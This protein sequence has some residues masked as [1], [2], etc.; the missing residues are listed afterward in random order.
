[1]VNGFCKKKIKSRLTLGEKF[2]Q[3]RKRKKISLLQAEIGSKVRSKYLEAIELGKWDQLPQEVYVR[4]FVLSYA[5]FLEITE[6]QILPLYESESAILREKADG[7][8]ISYN[9]TIETNKKVLI[10]PRLLAFSALGVFVLGMVSYIV[11]QLSDFAGNPN[12]KITEP[13]NNAVY[14][15]DS[16]DMS[17]ITDDD[18]VVMINEEK[19]PVTSDGHFALNL[20]LHKGINVIKVKAV[21]K[22]QKE[23]SEVFTVEYKP[24]TAAI[25]NT[26]I[27]Q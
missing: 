9:Q 22:I 17:G 19:V 14:E 12:L 15:I 11:I 26:V 6:A 8:K 24:K 3:V 7:N 18:T 5:K 23:T 25:V 10:T 20:K 4:G 27:G 16:I 1:M 2:Q 21:N 13:Q